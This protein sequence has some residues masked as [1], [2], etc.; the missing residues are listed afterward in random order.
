MTTFKRVIVLICFVVVSFIISG[1]DKDKQSPELIVETPEISHAAGAD[2]ELSEYIMDFI[3]Y[4]DNITAV[5]DIKIEIVDFGGY[6]K[7]KKGTYQ[8]IIRATDKAGNYAEAKL[9]VIVTDADT[10]PPALT[11]PVTPINH[12]AGEEVDLTQGLE[13]VDDVDGINVKFKVTDFGTYNKGLP[14]SY[15]VK[16]VVYDNAGNESAPFNR[17]IVVSESFT[18]AEMVSFAGEVIRHEAL[19]NPQVLGGHTATGYN[20]AYDGHY[21][22]VLSKEYVEWLINY[23]PERIGSGI[24]W[25]VIAVTDSENKIVYVR[26]WNSGEA[27]LDQDSK[28]VSQHAVD[29][30]TGTNRNWNEE[31][32]GKL[33]AFTNARYS[34]GEMGMMMANINRWIP[35]GGHVFIFMNWTTIGLDDNEEVVAIA[36]SSTMPRAMGAN[37]IMN[38]DEDGDDVMDYALGRELKVID[39]ALSNQ[40]IRKSFD[41]AKPFPIITLPGMRTVT[42]TGVWRTGYIQTVYL[43]EYNMQNPYDPLLG[44]TANDGKGNDITGQITFKVYPYVTTEQEYGFLTSLPLTDSHWAE[45]YDNTWKLEEN[46]IS[47][48]NILGTANDQYYYVIEYTVTANGFTDKVYRLIQIKAESP[49]YI[50]LYDDSDSVYTVVMGIQQRLEMNP[51]LDEFGAMNATEKGILYDY[52]TYKSLSKLPVFDKGVVVVL[53]EFYRIKVVRVLNNVAFEITPSGIVLLDNL[54]W[55]EDG[56][57]DGIDTIIS[58]GGYVI[59]YPEGKD[60]IVLIKALRAFVDYDYQTGDITAEVENGAVNVSLVIKEVQEVSTLLVNDEAPLINISGNDVTIKVVENSK[61][62]LIFYPAGGGAGFRLDTGKVYYFTKEMYA[63]LSQATE[64]VE[65]FT[66]S[67][68][69]KG[70]PWFRDGSIVVL[71]AE[72]NFVLAR[73]MTTAAAAEI[74]ADGTVIY[75][76]AAVVATSEAAKAAAG[77]PNLSF[78]IVIP[79]AANTVAHGPL[80]DILEIVPEGGSFLIFP[81]T[82]NT[83]V[84][85]FSVRLLWNASYPGSGIIVDATAEEPPAGSPD[86]AT[87]GFNF[88]NYNSDYFNNL[89]FK[90]D[91][92][93][94]ITDKAVKLARPKV[95]LEANTISWTPISGA[96]SYDLYIDGI[97]AQKGIG[98]L[99]ETE[100]LYNFNLSAISLP[101]ATYK[102]QVRAIT[103]NPK[104]NSTSVLSG[105]V[106]FELNRLNSPNPESFVLNDNIL[107]WDEIDGASE[108]LVSIN[109]GEYFAVISNQVA[110]PDDDLTAGTTV[111]V[112]AAGSELLFDSVPTEHILDVEVI[113]KEIVLGNYTLPVVEFTV[114][115]WLR[116]ADPELGNDVGGASVA[117]IIVINEADEIAALADNV[118]LINGG[119]AAVL[120]SELKVKY[121]VDRWGHEWNPTD[122][123]TTNA[124]GWDYGT[125]LFASYFK[126]YLAEGDILVMASQW[127]EGLEEGNYRNYF[128]NALI[129][130]LGTVT[131]EPGKD[132]RM[133]ELTNAINPATVNIE[134]KIV[135]STKTIAIG[136]NQLPMVDFTLDDWLNYADPLGGN[137]V[138][139][140]NV[141]GIIVVSGAY[142]IS[143][144]DDNV[145]LI[146]GGYAALLD[147][148]LKVKYIVDR[149]GHEWNS[150]DGWTTNAGGWDYG[151]NLFASYFKPYL[152]E[153]DILVMAS[154]W[155]KGLVVGSYRN[156]F[157]NALI[158]NL[159]TVTTD[160]RG[161]N[162]EEALNP[163]TVKFS[164]REQVKVLAIGNSMF[165]VKELELA[166]W[167]QYADPTG[168]NDVGAQWIPGIV[169]VKGAKGISELDDNVV[170][171]NG[172]YIAVVDSEFK[173]KY[174]V[175]RWAHEWNPTDGWSTNQ[176]GWDWALNLK[177]SYFKS[178]LAEGDMLIMASQYGTG[179]GAGTYRNVFGNELIFN[180]NTVTTD[181]RGINIAE[182]L[183]PST[184]NIKLIE[185]E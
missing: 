115:A 75:G 165:N 170:I 42:D 12:I 66:T 94:T 33:V 183:N 138:G 45:Y 177:A 164:F 73:V 173:V 59:I 71:D 17:T 182:A 22:N 21:V 122:G 91:F 62:A 41:A 76:N 101:A 151:A 181:H 96:A 142:G 180:L 36:N 121:I 128:G 6:D 134:I 129:Y 172:G 137:D 166:E 19:Y 14:G 145:K 103:A 105:A 120:D 92:V 184:I 169:L 18:R 125:N 27:F 117:G 11:S 136:G 46:E 160:H 163:K 175:D 43:N 102:L 31:I 54:A 53:D 64:V 152:V 10:T 93:A 25:S 30:S 57:L 157:G 70:V 161:V 132:H 139:A 40:S 126:P 156:H 153:G 47:L 49:D 111:K 24:G 15:V 86:P 16:I 162:L 141:A 52:S 95:K 149:W 13:G 44:V 3:S 185:L 80:V 8:I 68:P 133:V 74:K 26:H 167:L 140:A 34:S 35:E 107:T 150:T 7:A 146:N 20:T 88:E 118:K 37:Y 106:M 110:I 104:T 81:G 23:A 48:E 1:C 55:I 56:I 2:I 9:T 65:S 85:N 158:K 99:N 78:D 179:L 83:A 144:L 90:V 50:E 29:W 130:D 98:T 100:T 123:W 84:R 124:G 39:P 97:L 4:S 51:D 119:Y 87:N 171:F 113:P 176:G 108:Y 114:N 127:S 79:N 72:G 5:A 28:L 77:E 32:D 112:I 67:S 89:K 69:N 116:H 131:P 61:E 155:N 168:G 63:V 38:S 174:I 159:G 147:A 109:N 60:G 178:Y 143:E 148:E 58:E 135:I 154:Q 82:A